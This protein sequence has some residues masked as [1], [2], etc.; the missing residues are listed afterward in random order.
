ML[1]THLNAFEDQVRFRRI[2][3]A[4]QHV[5]CVCCFFSIC[6]LYLFPTLSLSFPL[7]LIS[8]SLTL[9]IHLYPISL[10]SLSHSPSHSLSPS[11]PFARSLS[12]PLFSL[13][14]SRSLSLYLSLSPPYLNFSLIKVV[15]LHKGL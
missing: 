7:S 3:F 11:L 10:F 4:F 9:Y 15:K 6:S 13:S 14:L 12:I 1:A 8:H 2:Y 5:N